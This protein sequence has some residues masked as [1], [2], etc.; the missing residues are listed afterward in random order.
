MR[1]GRGEVKLDLRFFLSDKLIILLAEHIARIGIGAAMLGIVFCA[2]FR[3]VQVGPGRFGESGVTL[4]LTGNSDISAKRHIRVYIR[5]ENVVRH[6]FRHTNHI[7][8]IIDAVAIQGAGIDIS[9]AGVHFGNDARKLI[10]LCK[11]RSGIRVE[12]AEV[13]RQIGDHA[14]DLDDLCFSFY[15][16]LIELAGGFSDGALRCGKPE[17]DNDRTPAAAHKELDHAIPPI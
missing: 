15:A 14:F 17:R 8:Q 10:Q 2:D 1:L 6:L 7:V 5:D 4:N 9:F 16:G 12:S 11:L 3:E 13:R